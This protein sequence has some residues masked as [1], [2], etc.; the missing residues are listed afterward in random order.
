MMVL[1]AALV[2]AEQRG[3]FAQEA[4]AVAGLVRRVVPSRK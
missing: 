1:P 4:R 2:W 3:S